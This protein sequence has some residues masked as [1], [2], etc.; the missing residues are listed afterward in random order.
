MSPRDLEKSLPD[1]QRYFSRRLM[2]I[3]PGDADKS[4]LKLQLTHAG[5]TEKYLPEIHGHLSG[6]LKYICLSVKE[7]FLGNSRHI[8]NG[9]SEK[10]LSKNSRQS[11]PGK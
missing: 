6:I 1:I 3:L 5:D 10:Y 9:D 7:M 4:L 2:D 8:S 11:L